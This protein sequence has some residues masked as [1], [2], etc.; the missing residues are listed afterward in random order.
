VTVFVLLAFA[1]LSIVHRVDLAATPL[2]KS[3]LLMIGV[4]WL[5]RGVAEVVFFRLGAEGAVWRLALFLVLS[6]IYILPA[7]P[8]RG[9]TSPTAM[10]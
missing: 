3:V 10:R 7:L 8:R 6:A 1:Y 9:H 2:G 5:I 4:V